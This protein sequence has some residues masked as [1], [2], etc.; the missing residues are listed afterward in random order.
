MLMDTVK[1]KL[2]YEV[3]EKGVVC[4]NQDLQNKPVCPPGPFLI[5]KPVMAIRNLQL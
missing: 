5:L 3:K 2:G 1:K 4:H